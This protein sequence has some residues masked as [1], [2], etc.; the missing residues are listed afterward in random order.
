MARY[1]APDEVAKVHAGLYNYFETYYSDYVM[2]SA[3]EL[4]KISDAGYPTRDYHS[5]SNIM[6]QTGYDQYSFVVG[7]SDAKVSLVADASRLEI[8]VLAQKQ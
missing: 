8:Y 5:I 4:M 3:C 6:L 1:P 7:E 2:I